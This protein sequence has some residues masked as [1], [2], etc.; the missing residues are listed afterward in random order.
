M[1]ARN[2]LSLCVIFLLSCEK[3]QVNKQVFEKKHEQIEY[4]FSSKFVSPKLVWINPNQPLNNNIKPAIFYTPH[5]DD[6]TLGMGA[7]IAEHVRVGRPV[8]VVLY[9]TGS[10]T[11]AFEV[12]NGVDSNGQVVECGYHNLVHNFNLSIQDFVFARNLEFIAACKA[13]GVHKV[14][15]SNN[16]LGYDET[17]GLAN[18]TFQYKELIHYFENLYPNAS[19]KLMSG[20]CDQTPFGTRHLCHRAAAEAVHEIYQTGQ[21]S[22]FRLYRDYVFYFPEINR[23]ADWIKQVIQVDK[24]KRQNALDEYGLFLP[25]NGRYAIGYE[26]S[27]YELFDNS[28]NSNWEY[29]DFPYNYCQ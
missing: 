1:F 24:E 21:I 2:F 20:N 22:D 28:Y 5:Q 18:M 29:I 27:V 9:S 3:T 26:H 17:V 16:G 12:L 15:I 23:N 4:I 10:L 6:E 25:Q 14:F 13:L 8:Y 7:S 11:G 19:H